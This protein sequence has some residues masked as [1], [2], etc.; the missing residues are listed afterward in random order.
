MILKMKYQKYYYCCSSIK[1]SKYNNLQHVENTF[2]SFIETNNTLQQLCRVF[3]INNKDVIIE[4]IY[5]RYFIIM[6]MLEIFT[7]QILKYILKIY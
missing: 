6:N 5:L 1:E 3:D 4:N 7:E 2:K